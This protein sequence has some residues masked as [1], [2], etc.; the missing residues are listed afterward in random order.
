MFGAGFWNIN[1]EARENAFWNV[2]VGARETGFWDINVGAE[3]TGFWSVSVDVRRRLKQLSHYFDSVAYRMKL[4]F[5][6]YA[7]KRDRVLKPSL[8]PTFARTRVV[9]TCFVV[10]GN[11]L[12]CRRSDNTLSLK[13]VTYWRPYGQV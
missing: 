1:V 2:N 8:R 11:T 6:D 3:T 7:S 10:A 4:F 12:L 9:C 5:M 13:E